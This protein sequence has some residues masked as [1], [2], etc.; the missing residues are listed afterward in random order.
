[1]CKHLDVSKKSTFPGVLTQRVV[2]HGWYLETQV[3]WEMMQSL[4][5]HECI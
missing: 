5:L 2:F 4:M 1:M 3:V